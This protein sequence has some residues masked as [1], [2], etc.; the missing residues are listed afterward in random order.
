MAG[1]A[2]IRNLVGIRHPGR[3]EAKC[4]AMDIDVSNRLLDGRHVT[5]DALTPGTTG[6]VVRV[7]F[8][9]ARVWSIRR[10]WPV[11]FQ[12]DDIGWFQ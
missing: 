4:V 1:C 6:L 10:P 7:F 2:W 12:T 8:D 3:N 5:G 9:C 11:A